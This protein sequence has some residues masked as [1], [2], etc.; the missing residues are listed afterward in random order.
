M[1]RKAGRRGTRKPLKAPYTLI[2]KLVQRF[3]KQTEKP[4]R[5]NTTT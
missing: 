5:G 3:V 2:R 1:P 4:T